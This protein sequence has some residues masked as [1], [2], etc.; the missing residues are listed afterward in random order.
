MKLI[1]FHTS[2]ITPCFLPFAHLSKS[3]VLYPT[4]KK[5]NVHVNAHKPKERFGLLRNRKESDFLPHLLVHVHHHFV[6]EKNSYKISMRT[7]RWVPN[8]K[9]MLEKATLKHFSK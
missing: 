4:G 3:S 1:K 7:A 6:H 2:F 8:T 5:K 9:G